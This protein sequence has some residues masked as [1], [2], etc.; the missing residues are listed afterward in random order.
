VDIDPGS[1][2]AGWTGAAGGRRVN[3]VHHQGVRA[4]GDGLRAEAVSVEDGIIEA[5]RYD[6]SGR[7]SPDN[8][9]PFAYGVQW[10]PEFQGDED[11][12]LLDGRPVLRA[13]LRAVDARR[14]RA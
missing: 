9:A 4:L 8:A 11:R 13:F 1:W 2:L 7:S 5:V 3:S 10:H 6:P 12:T 14:A